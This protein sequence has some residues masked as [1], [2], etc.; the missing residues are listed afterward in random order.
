MAVLGPVSATLARSG[1]I[2][3]YMP[4][5][6]ACWLFVPSGTPVS[7]NPEYFFRITTDPTNQ[8]RS[9]QPHVVTS[10]NGTQFGTGVVIETFNVG[11]YD[12]TSDI[13]S[14][15][16]MGVWHHWCATYVDNGTPGTFVG[17]PGSSGCNQY[18]DAVLM[19]NAASASMTLQFVQNDPL[20]QISLSSGGFSN[21]VTIA[22]PAVW[23]AALTVAEITQLAKGL[24]PRRIRPASLVSFSLLSGRASEINSCPDLCFANPYVASGGTFSFVANPPLRFA[25]GSGG[26]GVAVAPPPPSSG[27]VPVPPESVILGTPGY[28]APESGPKLVLPSFYTNPPEPPEFPTL[29]FGG[30][31]QR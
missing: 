18:M 14:Q 6:Q 12:Q 30:P 16:N 17:N 26:S 4:L 25:L 8:H 29:I 2:S 21:V 7:G 23:K 3:A 31:W 11:S 10:S 28:P 1:G 19:D 20:G 13:P 22:F 24:D 15:V 27:G 9:F 5:T